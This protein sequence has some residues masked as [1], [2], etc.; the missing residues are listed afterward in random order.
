MLNRK[1]KTAY[2]D[3]ESGV[4]ERI[5]TD[6]A[7]RENEGKLAQV[8]RDITETKK[9]QQRLQQSQKME[10][11]GTLAGGIAH[12]FNNILF[13]FIGHTEMLMEDASEDSPFR[14]SLDHIYSSALRAKDLVQQILAFSRQE[15]N[16]LRLMKMQ[17]IIK[18][19]LKLIRSTI[20]AT[21]HIKQD[22]QSDCGVVQADPTQIH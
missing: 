19:V 8:L 20:P 15:K 3:L 6:K 7:L 11:I 22:L 5:Q 18:E 10:A 4:N 13:P 16:E 12:D 14:H 17:P 21:I 9:M 2:K 1:I